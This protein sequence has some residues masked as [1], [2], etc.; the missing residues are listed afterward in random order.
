MRFDE[1]LYTIL[2][3]GLLALTR[4]QEHLFDSSTYERRSQDSA[5]LPGA[6]VEGFTLTL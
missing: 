5:L 3:S 6:L 2:G 1:T 4:E